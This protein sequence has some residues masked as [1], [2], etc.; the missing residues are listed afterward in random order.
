MSQ[1]F[2]TILI[3]GATS[4]IGEAFARRYHAQGKKVIAAGRRLNRLEALKAELKGLEIFQSLESNFNQ[5]LK[6]F[7]TLDTVFMLS[8]VL[9][10]FWFKDPST[11]TNEDIINEVAVN[12][13][14]PI[15]AARLL[16]PHLLSLNRPAAFLLITS[17]MAFI[18]IPL[19]P[20]YC[21]TKAAIHSFAITL[22]GQ[23]E[24][25]NVSVIELAPPYVDTAL[26]AKSRGKD[27]NPMPPMPLDEFMD[28]AMK[29]LE[30]TE[31]GKPKKEV[32]VGFAETGVST[33]RGAFGPILKNFG[34][35]K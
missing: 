6:Q 27:G 14:A 11:S 32:A 21:P 20:V 1:Q 30:E 10:Q 33:W 24:G 19:Y 5:L 29:G 7:P 17:G 12:T 3:L 9:S 4:G 13:T 2:E 31:N 15:L 34:I 8:G 22:R 28:S 23:L 35:E 18:P 25:T 26:D 16:I